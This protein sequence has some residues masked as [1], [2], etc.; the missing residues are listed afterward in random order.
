[1]PI[2]R[3]ALRPASSATPEPAASKS[4][5]PGSGATDP[6]AAAG[7]K[8][9]SGPR[10]P[11]AWAR[12]LMR[13]ME[14][15]PDSSLNVKLRAAGIDRPPRAF[16]DSVG[17]IADPQKLGAIPPEALQQAIRGVVDFA[18]D[19]YVAAGG[20][21]SPFL[22]T[23]ELVPERSDGLRDAV[24]RNDHLSMGPGG[25]LR[26][27]VPAARVGGRASPLGSEQLQAQWDAGRQFTDDRARRAWP[28]LNPTGEIRSTLRATV[29]DAATRL[30]D[31]LGD[32]RSKTAAGDPGA[33]AA[34]Q[35]LANRYVGPEVKA[36]DGAPL[37][38]AIAE[39]ISGA[40]QAQ[41]ASWAGD[42]QRR[43]GDAGFREEVL[44]Q[45]VDVAR[46]DQPNLKSEAIGLVAVA[47]SHQIDVVADATVGASSVR[48]F[49]SRPESS[50]STHV[51]AVGL[52]AVATQD[53]I[54]VRATLSALQ[55]P[56]SAAI[57]GEALARSFGL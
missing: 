8:A 1:M 21:P 55:G 45:V 39:R 30:S 4:A 12:S 33:R 18:V 53:T 52:V 25:A 3:A 28:L 49:V 16:A 2:Q 6:G 41:L 35:A 5:P 31:E 44:G 43:V 11:T 46:E 40:S 23:I 19:Q 42:W 10:H 57:A 54:N 13:E 17:V 14:Q 50:R 38:T 27:E 15:D 20:R 48:R 29:Q 32:L 9:G 24:L 22:K 56:S 47:N 7:W 26:V 34:F 51:R 37:R 36:S